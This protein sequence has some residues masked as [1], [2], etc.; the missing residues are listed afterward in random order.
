MAYIVNIKLL[1]PNY[2]YMAYFLSLLDKKHKNTNKRPT[3][4]GSQLNTI[5]LRLTLQKVS[6]LH[7]KLHLEI[8]NHNP[9]KLGWEG[10]RSSKNLRLFI[11]KQ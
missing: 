8:I 2:M 1:V 6:F 11:P 5:A 10:K 4:L 3:G 7:F 9:N